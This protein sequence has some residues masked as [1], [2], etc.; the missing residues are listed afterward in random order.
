[1]L[2]YVHFVCPFLGGLSS[3]GVSLIRCFTVHLLPLRRGQPLHKD[4]QLIRPQP[5]PCREAPL[6]VMLS[7][8]SLSLQCTRHS[9]LLYKQM[10]LTPMPRPNPHTR[11]PT[12]HMLHP[13]PHAQGRLDHQQTLLPRLD[14]PRPQAQ[15]Q[16]Q[17]ASQTSQGKRWDGLYL[18]YTHA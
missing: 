17:P 6:Y 12:S 11:D 13:A 18:E 14:S 8:L 5:V 9:L 4:R 16:L 2:E 1:M 15:D 3:F 10:N 7:F